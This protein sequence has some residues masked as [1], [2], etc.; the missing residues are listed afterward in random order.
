MNFQIWNLWNEAL[1]HPGAGMDGILER[2]PK[3]VINPVQSNLLFLSLNP[4]FP[5]RPRNELIHWYQE[6]GFAFPES[7]DW[8]TSGFQNG[9]EPALAQSHAELHVAARNQYPRFF[10]R[11][12]ILANHRNH[13]AYAHVDLFLPLTPRLPRIA[14]SAANNRYDPENPN[15]WQKQLDIAY[16]LIAGYRPTSIV[17]VY[18][19][20]ADIFLRY[21]FS[22]FQQ[23]LQP[24][25]QLEQ[26]FRKVK[27]T[28]LQTEWQMDPVR[29]YRVCDL[30]NTHG[31][32]PDLDFQLV[33][34]LIMNDAGEQ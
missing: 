31:N 3:F 20:A 32:L 21:F 10:E 29:F 12:N 2:V 22:R 1:I 24:F 6:Q 33:C 7:F 34:G 25:Q 14:I 19:S 16:D 5:S 15:F 27:R 26:G 13:P 28:Y 9:F 11:M 23:E 17:A 30:P 18:A 4:S 8:E